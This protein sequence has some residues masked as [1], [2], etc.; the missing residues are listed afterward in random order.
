MTIKFLYNAFNKINKKDI[1]NVPK[2]SL[3]THTILYFAVGAITAYG[4]GVLAGASHTM[5]ISY[6]VSFG[7]VAAL[8]VGY[9]YGAV[10]LINHADNV[11]KLR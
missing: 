7:A 1:I 2:L 9:V 6:A 11:E 8:V 10:W 5:L 4:I 3:I